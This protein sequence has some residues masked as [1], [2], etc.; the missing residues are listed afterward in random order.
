MR[1]SA[2]SELNHSPWNRA[3]TV[4]LVFPLMVNVTLIPGMSTKE[5]EVVHCVSVAFCDEKC[6]IGPFTCTP[7]FEAGAAPA[8]AA[9]DVVGSPPAP[10]LAPRG[11]ITSKADVAASRNAP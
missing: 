4:W 6:P 7:G 3:R 1:A 9:F 8:A 5:V 10:A 11:L 2:L